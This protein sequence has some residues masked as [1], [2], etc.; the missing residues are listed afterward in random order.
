[1]IE[2][3]FTEIKSHMEKTL[4]ILA[5]ELAKIRTGRATPELLDSIPVEMYGA[6]MKIKQIATISIPQPRLIKIVPFDKSTFATIERAIRTSDLGINPRNDG[7]SIMLELPAPTEERR[8]ELAKLARKKGEEMKIAIRNV[9]RDGKDE[10]EML[11]EEK[12]ITEDD[13]DRALK[14]LQDLTDDYIK[15]ID[16][17]IEK[18]EKEIIEF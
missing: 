17:L 9:R 11:Q 16:T 12:E 5:A 13:R 18:K 6:P 4:D 8:K 7:L 1:M 15:K 14:K 3:T 10:I 2:Q